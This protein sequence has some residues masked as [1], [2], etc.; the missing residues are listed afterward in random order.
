MF[1]S[2]LVRIILLSYIGFAGFVLFLLWRNAAAPDAL[3]NTGVLFASML[4]V[5]IAVFPYLNQERITRDF[6][7]DFFYDSQQKQIITGDRFNSYDSNYIYMFTNLSL[8]PN[9]LNAK[10]F[11]EV[12]E[13]KGF[14]I[15]EKGIIEML[16]MKFMRHWDI[17]TKKFEGPIGKS[18]SWGAASKLPLTKIK[19]SEIQQIFE[20]NQF[21]V[22]PGVL[23]HPDMSVPPNTK[24]TTKTNK[25]SRLIIFENPYT[26]VEISIFPF[27]GSVAQHGIWG[28]LKIDPANP[29][30]YY[31]IEYRIVASQKLS[32]TKVYSPQMQNYKRW[33][34]NICD[35]LQKCDWSTVDEQVEKN[36]TREAVSK[37]LEI[38]K[39]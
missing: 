6:T 3:K 4:P 15:I 33:F 25:H 9:A 1:D 30:R 8:I 12:M 5:V 29:N 32:R 13:S 18:E 39:P 28:V 7:F 14:D 27:L 16:F 31:A 22:T 11:S 10:D 26:T 20:H 2:T 24:I 21:I 37:I 36:L 34:E 23:V 17:E 38:E 35:I 19:L